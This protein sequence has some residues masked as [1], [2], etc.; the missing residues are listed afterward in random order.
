M[1]AQPVKDREMS[2][3]GRIW[4]GAKRAARWIRD[5]FMG[6]ARWTGDKIR[7]GASWLWD[8][9][10]AGARRAKALAQ[11]AWSWA[12]ANGAK[13]WGW[14]KTAATGAW[15]YVTQFFAW[16]ATP[17]R[18]AITSTGVLA[19]GFF[20]SPWFLLAVGVVWIGYLLWTGG[21]KEKEKRE[22]EQGIVYTTNAAG[23][24]IRQL[25]DEES[26]AISQRS[27]ELKLRH[28][29]MSSKYN[30]SQL[31]EAD[32]EMWTFEM[33]SDGYFEEIPALKRRFRNRREEENALRVHN[34][35]DAIKWNW[36]AANRGIVKAVKE[37]E[38]I[39]VKVHEAKAETKA[40]AKAEPLSRVPESVL[41]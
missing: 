24:R 31:S 14:T 35:N 32:A 19:A 22:R 10:K 23:D 28:S 38:E 6:A 8:K 26:L 17:L 18:L 34:G 4:D 39:L 20:F 7:T 30:D 36:T 5:R 1:S 37:I 41:S 13:A 12:K 16:V 15:G 25:T 3:F 21:K 11:R 33:R 9:A 2:F 27:A 40:E 29:S